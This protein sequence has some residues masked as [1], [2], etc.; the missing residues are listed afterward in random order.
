MIDTKG[1]TLK[2][3][4]NKIN[5]FAIPK[6]IIFRVY[7]W[8]ND[9]QS[10]IK[11]IKKKF[12]KKIILRSSTTHEDT[13][14]QSAAGAFDS[15]LNVNANNTKEIQK[16]IEKIIMSYKKKIRTISNQQ[17]LIQEMIR[18]IKMSGVIFTG[19][20]LGYDNYYTINYDDITGRSDTVTSGSSA[21]SNKSLYIY[22]AKKKIVRTAR[23]KKIIKA[24]EE[25][26]KYLK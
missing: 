3:L 18:N 8:R 5:I 21:Y 24:T 2:N 14:V 22:K 9:K 23:F 10:I 26:E 19:N 13:T 15:F 7:E 4:E 1:N 6:T 25:I 17:I 20:N 11:R 12:K 16:Y